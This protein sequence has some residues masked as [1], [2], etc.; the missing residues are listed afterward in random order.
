MVWSVEEG[1]GMTA[2]SYTDVLVDQIEVSRKRVA[3]RLP[4]RGM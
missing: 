2:D 4:I 3:C 1:A